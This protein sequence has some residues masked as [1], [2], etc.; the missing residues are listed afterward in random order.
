MSRIPIRIASPSKYRAVRTDGYASKKEA[1][2]GAELEMLQKTGAIYNLEKQKR[3]TL[4]PAYPQRGFSHPLVYIADF[5]YMDSATECLR[6]EDVKGF[7]T[8]VYK[9]KRR[10][11][12][13][14]LHIEVTEV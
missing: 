10:L 5:T 9:I 3:F 1:K 12:A 2:R 8:E 11:M 7:K 14:L 13:Q 6:I 4:L